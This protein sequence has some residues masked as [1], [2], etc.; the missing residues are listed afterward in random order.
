MKRKRREFRETNL[1]E[2]RKL[3]NRLDLEVWQFSDIHFRVVGQNSVDYW[4]SR[5]TAWLLGST[6]K[7]R[8]MTVLEICELA[9]GIIPSPADLL[10]AQMDAEFREQLS[11]AP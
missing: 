6:E 3:K 9:C 1:R 7:G 5:G 11:L 2:L 4:P 8:K 10:N